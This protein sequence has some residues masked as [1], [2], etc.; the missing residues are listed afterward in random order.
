M[1]IKA[2]I[3]KILPAFKG[4]NYRLHVW[5]QLISSSG[6]WLQ[7]VTM[8]WYIWDLTHSESL[9]ALILAMPRCVSACLTIFGGIISDKFDKRAVLYVTNF[10]GMAQAMLLGYMVIN[11]VSRIWIVILLSI[12][13]GLINAIDGPARHSF[14]PEIVDR[15]EI[16]Q[17]SS[18][19]SAIGQS[20]QFVGSSLGAVL[21]GLIGTGWTFVLNGLSFMAVII[22]LRMMKIDKKTEI[23]KDQNNYFR[24]FKEGVAYVARQPKIRWYL[25]L[26]GSL[27]FFGFSYR[28]ILPVVVEQIFHSGAKNYAVLMACAGIGAL[29]GS[30]LSS[31]K[32]K[33]SLNFFVV[34]GSLI[35]GSALI[36]FTLTSV[37]I[38]GMSL[39]FAAGFG[40]TLSSSSVRGE[41]QEV[42]SSDMRGRVNGFV[43]MFALG[44]TG[45]GGIVTGKL[46]ELFGSQLALIVSGVMLIII[47]IIVFV[48][49]RLSKH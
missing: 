35:V 3:V 42:M 7:N 37:F 25:V 4:R 14:L 40:L 36:L 8:G 19:N 18:F 30:T 38:L 17:T 10:L 27:N 39:M 9:T 29:I 45:L 1:S 26:I 34:C 20:S 31:A 24:M 47:A 16:R 2:I 6:T 43:M 13:L 48:L 28:G 21:L 12:C 23:R 32:S 44:G 15:T 46:A 5:G 22:M 11:N 49:D 41:C 33:I